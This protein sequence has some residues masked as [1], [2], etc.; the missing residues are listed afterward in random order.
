MCLRSL[1][2]RRVGDLFSDKTV[3]SRLVSMARKSVKGVENVYTQHTP[4]MATT[5]VCTVNLIPHCTD[6]CG[7]D[8][9]AHC[10]TAF[11][12]RLLFTAVVLSV[13]MC[14][15]RRRPWRAAACR[16]WT[17]PTLAAPRRRPPLPRS[18]L[19]I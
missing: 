1:L 13:L 6:C 3:S 8:H 12:V 15:Y 18:V 9:P 4:L 2:R 14:P 19:Q 5:L 17:T 11:D 16:I 10:A 7:N